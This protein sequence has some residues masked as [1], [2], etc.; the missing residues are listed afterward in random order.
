MNKVLLILLF[1]II[2]YAKEDYYWENVAYD[3]WYEL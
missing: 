2:S 3:K 1:V